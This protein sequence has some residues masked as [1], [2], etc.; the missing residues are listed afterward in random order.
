MNHNAEQMILLTI[1]QHTGCYTNGGENDYKCVRRNTVSTHE[2][3]RIFFAII[4]ILFFR[5]S[6][7][8]SLFVIFFANY[9]NTN[10]A[11]SD[12]GAA[13]WTTCLI[14]FEF[15]I[16]NDL[17]PRRAVS[18]RNPVRAEA[19]RYERRYEGNRLI[20]T[21]SN[22]SSNRSRIR[23]TRLRSGGNQAVRLRRPARC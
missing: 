4:H 13:A 7:L 17:F 3:D 12:E 11:K 19:E 15:F 14:H 16:R 22:S 21:R 20:E 23:S 18:G 5:N 6:F 10:E 1:F 9:S 8:A 2:S